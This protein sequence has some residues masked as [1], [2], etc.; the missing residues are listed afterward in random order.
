MTA[1]DAFARLHD[2]GCV[3]AM[4]T[5]PACGARPDVHEDDEA[6]QQQ[7]VASGDTRDEGAGPHHGAK[8]IGAPLQRGRAAA[9]AGDRS[10]LPRQG[11]EELVSIG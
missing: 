11:E 4:S 2:R 10:T 9:L 5:S 3:V 7:R 1:T 6:G 8:Y